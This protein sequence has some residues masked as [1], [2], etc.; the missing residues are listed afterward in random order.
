LLKNFATSTAPRL[1]SPTVPSWLLLTKRFVCL[2]FD[3]AE[4][5]G[6]L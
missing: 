1:T 5:G 2:R 6:E 3:V 4:A